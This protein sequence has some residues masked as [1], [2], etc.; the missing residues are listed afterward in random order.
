MMKSQR[1]KKQQAIK[2]KCDYNLQKAMAI[3]F[4]PQDAS[5]YIPRA[6][7]IVRE[8]SKEA[9]GPS[10]KKNFS[11]KKIN[12]DNSAQK[13]LIVT[14]INNNNTAIKGKIKDT[15]SKLSILKDSDPKLYKKMYD[16]TEK[17]LTEVVNQLPGAK[18]VG[19]TA[20]NAL[21]VKL[22][23]MENGKNF[24]SRPRKLVN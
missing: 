2:N 9:R 13:D 1:A 8:P 20:Q 15:I 21:E 18:S 11:L 12:L 10:A 23:G 14:E 19:S 16:E 6:Q 4:N 22:Q 24:S 17:I 7:S 3:L 5:I